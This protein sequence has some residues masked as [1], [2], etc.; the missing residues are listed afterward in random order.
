MAQ[1]KLEPPVGVELSSLLTIRGR[2]AAY[3]WLAETLH[4]AVTYN[5]VR[6]CIA[7]GDIPFTDIRG[8]KCFSTLDLFTWASQLGDTKRQQQLP[9][10]WGAS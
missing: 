7:N 2:K 4:L 9:A 3:T 6:E 1:T 5:F 10:A 8:V